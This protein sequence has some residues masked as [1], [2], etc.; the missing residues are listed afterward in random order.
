MAGQ[1]A[2]TQ[3][4]TITLTS[5]GWTDANFVSSSCS[6][7]VAWEETSS[8]DGSNVVLMVENGKMVVALILTVQDPVKLKLGK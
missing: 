3:F 2:S 8:A 5:P 4:S 6:S 7:E 1:V